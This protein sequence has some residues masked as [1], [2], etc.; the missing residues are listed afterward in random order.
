MLD[1]FIL[2][3]IKMHI[4]NYYV[5][6]TMIPRR[7]ML[8][9]QMCFVCIKDWRVLVPNVLCVYKGLARIGNRMLFVCVRPLLLCIN[10][11]LGPRREKIYSLHCKSL[12]REIESTDK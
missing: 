8:S 5:H 11:M 1:E 6:N 12:Q 3:H 4:L 2:Q 10:K 9:D 7:T